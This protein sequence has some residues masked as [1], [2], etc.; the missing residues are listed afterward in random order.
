MPAYYLEAITVTLGIFLLVAEAFVPGKQKSWVGLAAIVGLLA[1]LA[2]TFRAIGPDQAPAGKAWASFALWDLY[3]YT[4]TAKFYKIVALVSAIFVLILAIDFRS[5]MARYTSGAKDESGTA[6]YYSLIVIA[7]AAMMW[8]ASAKHLSMLFVSLELLTVTFYILVAFMKRNVGSLEAGVKYLILGALST[9]FLVYGMAWIYGATGTLSMEGIAAA[10]QATPSNTAL[11][12]GLSLMIIALGFKVGA[13]PMH[14]WIPDVYQGAPTPTTAFLSVGSKAAGF[15][16]LITVVTPF[17]QSPYGSKIYGVLAIL[18]CLTLLVGNFGAIPQN[19]FKRLL[20]YSSIAN[21]GFLLLA[22]AAN[23]TDTADL[24]SPQIV[25]FYLAGYLIMTLAAFFVLSIVRVQTDS[26]QID[27]LDGLAKRNPLLAIAI[28]V[29]MASLAGVPLTVGFL[30]KLFVF[31]A[32]VDAGMHTSVM[33]AA[34]TAAAGFYYYFKILRAV[35]WNAPHE[36][37][38]L[39]LRGSSI[40]TFALALLTV[41]IVVFGFYP[42]PLL[43]LI[44]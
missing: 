31:R 11:L 12:F 32:A 27:A 7:T 16:A 9:G 28:T 5:V 21:A 25:G 36:R 37:I 6:E 34:I 17:A 2:L 14:F 1:V 19:N 20:A 30:G 40:F 42:Q 26:D 24:T 44:R 13:A 10:A 43:Q 29:I 41:A 3:Q 23:R 33:I 35:W 18:A 39:S 38:T 4:S 15:M 22:L 8:M